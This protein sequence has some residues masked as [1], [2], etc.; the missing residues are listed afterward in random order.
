[1]PA[2]ALI[3]GFDGEGE[4]DNEGALLVDI[5]GGHGY[6]IQN[7][8]RRFPGA[9]GRLILQDLGAVIDDIKVLDEGVVRMKYDFFTEQP[10]KGIIPPCPSHRFSDHRRLICYVRYSLWM[11][12]RSSVLPPLHLPRLVRRQVQGDP[13]QYRGGDGTGVFARVDQ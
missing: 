6:D 7:F 13:G 10:V 4:E 2:D 12:R 5:G 11:Y 3:K 1:M 9:P 8:G